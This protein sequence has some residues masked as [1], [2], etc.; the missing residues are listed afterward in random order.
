MD[1]PLQPVGP[2]AGD[3]PDVYQGLRTMA[4][5]VTPQQ[6]GLEGEVPEGTL[7][8]AIFEIGFDTGNATLVS[9]VDGT[10][11][12]YFN[13]GG[14]IIGA[15]MHE[16]VRAASQAFMA[17]VFK[18]SQQFFPGEP[19]ALPVE[20]ESTII[21]VATGGCYYATER[22]DVLGSGD[23]PLSPAF[24]AAHHLLFELRQIEAQQ[25]Q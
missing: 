5:R 9:L 19:A 7:L 3:A 21:V 4:M 8:G 14:G 12:L 6:L 11:S 22:D 17:A 1:S 25:Q 2:Q 20:D 10:T 18:A 23:S 16:T 13:T 24:T 15:G